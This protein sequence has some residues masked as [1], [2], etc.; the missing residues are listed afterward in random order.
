M[1]VMKAYTLDMQALLALQRT[2]DRISGHGLPMYTLDSH[3]YIPDG[4][5]RERWINI[6]A[7][8]NDRK[9]TYSPE[10]GAEFVRKNN[11]ELTPGQMEEWFGLAE[12]TAGVHKEA[13]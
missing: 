11:P 2:M 3:I 5:F 8:N 9:G 10:A 4:P 7:Q 13:V 6:F 12:R 1:W